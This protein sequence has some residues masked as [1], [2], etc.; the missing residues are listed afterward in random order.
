MILLL[1]SGCCHLNMMMLLTQYNYVLKMCETQKNRWKE[2][3]VYYP[4]GRIFG[5]FCGKKIDLDYGRHQNL[6]IATKPYV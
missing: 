5:H 6:A 4:T 1:P 3:D 2:K